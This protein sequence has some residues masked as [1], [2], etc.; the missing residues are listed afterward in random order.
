MLIVHSGKGE[1]RCGNIRISPDAAAPD[2]SFSNMDVISIPYSPQLEKAKLGEG[3]FGTVF[4]G[5]YNGR[6]VAVK[7]LQGDLS[8]EQLLEFHHEVFIMR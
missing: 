3:S 7:R 5:E 1:L 6:E 2:L 4:A 8:K